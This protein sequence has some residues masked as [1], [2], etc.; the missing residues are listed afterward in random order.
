MSNGILT[1]KACRANTDMT[2][3]EF[4]KAIGVDK[5]TVLNWEKGRTFPGCRNSKRS[6]K[7]RMCR[8]RLFFYPSNPII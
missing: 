2:Q 1:I 3:I 8:S 5:T 4:A 7:S 6:A